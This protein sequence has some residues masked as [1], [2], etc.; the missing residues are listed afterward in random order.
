MVM[1][2]AQKI[3]LAMGYCPRCE[4]TY[5]SSDEWNRARREGTNDLVCVR[6]GDEVICRREQ[7]YERRRTDR[8]SHR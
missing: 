2:E 4:Q 7:R 5:V 1:T 8:A 3:S 6:F